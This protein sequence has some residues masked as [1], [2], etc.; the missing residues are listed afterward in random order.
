[1]LAVGGETCIEVSGEPSTTMAEFALSVPSCAVM[2]A[3]PPDS[4]VTKPPA[5]TLATLGADEVQVTML[6]ITCVLPSLYVPVATQFTEV[7]G[8]STALAGVTEMEVSVAELTFSGALPETPLKVAEILAVPGPIA[9]ALPPAATVVTAGLSEAQV[10]S[11]VMTCLVRSLKTPVAAK[12][13]L[14]PGAMVRPEGVTEMD[15]IVALETLSV[16]EPLI[17]SS[18]AVMVVDPGVRPF[19]RP[20][21]AIVATAVL[22][23]VH[24]TC[25]VT[26]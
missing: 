20:P 10:E 1:M 17:E 4:A 15:T 21:R 19:A 8:A 26:L 13:N 14:V 22:D 24:D 9:V 2:V 6:V 16:V 11:L 25:P 3:F 5:V 18:V 7:V 23:E 12:A